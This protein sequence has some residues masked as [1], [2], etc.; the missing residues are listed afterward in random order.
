MKQRMKIVL[1]GLG[2]ALFLLFCAAVYF[3]CCFSF[4]LL[5]VRQAAV[6]AFI[7]LVMIR[8]VTLPFFAA[9]KRDPYTDAF[10][11]FDGLGRYL[12]L[13]TGDLVKTVL[14]I[15]FLLPG[16]GS[17]VMWYFA[18]GKGM[19]LEAAMLFVIGVFLTFVGGGIHPLRGVHPRF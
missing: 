3:G 4:G 13:L 19:Y 10:Y 18:A 11:Y 12:G 8:A 15:L 14:R 1:C 2:T 7:W 16:I 9:V 6:M 17:L 5:S